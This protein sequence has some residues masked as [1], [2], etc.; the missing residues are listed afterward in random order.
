MKLIPLVSI[1]CAGLLATSAANAQ[2]F[3]GTVGY[4]NVNPDSDNGTLADAQASVND[5]W[6]PTGSL[7]YYFTPSLFAEVG[8]TLGSF[9]HE[10][11]LAGLGTVATLEH[12]PTVLSINYQFLPEAKFRPFVRLGYAWIN[13]SNEQTQG[14]LAGLD[15]SASDADGLVFGAGVDF[16]VNDNLFIRADV[17]QLD[18]DTDV[19]VESLGA[20]GTAEV[21][22]IVYGVSIGYKF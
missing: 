17:S 9:E 6:A 5:D 14:A 1:V 21:D 16:A 2:S 15:I 7:G 13:I 8:T 12:R 3:F 11:T 18:F 4:T 22:P 20:V 19:E 10:V